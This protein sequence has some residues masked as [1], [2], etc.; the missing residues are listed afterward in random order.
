MAT[1]GVLEYLKLAEESL[2]QAREHLE[3][4]DLHLA[5]EKGWDGAVSAVRAVSAAY[6]NQGAF[7]YVDANCFSPV[8][9][10]VSLVWG[11]GRLLLL[12]GRAEALR[13]N[14]HREKTPLRREIITHDLARVTE[15][16]G[17]SRS[18][19]NDAGRISGNP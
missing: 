13:A 2:R 14:R 19:A 4:G 1:R 5:S 3:Q 16:V 7:Q 18:I 17:I 9:E 8:L 6:G 11:N 10:H 15:L 12:A